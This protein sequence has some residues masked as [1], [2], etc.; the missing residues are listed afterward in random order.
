M[1]VN[2]PVDPS[3]IDI[4]AID[5]SDREFWAGRRR[6]GTRCSTSCG[7]ERPFAFFAEPDDAVHRRPA[8]ATT[9]SPGY[10]D[11]DGDQLPAGACSAPG[12]GA[13]SIQDIPA[14]LNEFYGSM[15]SMDDPR[16]ARIRRIVAKTFTPRMLERVVDSVRG[17]RRRRR[18]PRPGARPRRATAPSTSSP[19]SP[20]RS[21]CGSSAT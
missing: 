16:H 18:S 11:L 13:V 10:A 21:R 12:Q 20:P 1:S 5:L 9:R 14:D 8:P 2:T 15:I 4:E 7:A 17:D 6:C 3:Q 19:T